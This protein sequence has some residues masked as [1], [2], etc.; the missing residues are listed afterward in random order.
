V[1]RWQSASKRRDRTSRP[2][3]GQGTG[4]SITEAITTALRE[5]LAREEGKRSALRIRDELL[6]I[7]RRCAALP[8]LDLRSPEEIF[9]YDEIGLPR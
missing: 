4:L 9:G 1:R 7:G 6:V 2:R 8:D 5:Q 3:V